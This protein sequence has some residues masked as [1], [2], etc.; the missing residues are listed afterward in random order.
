MNY[1]YLQY[2]MIVLEKMIQVMKYVLNSPKYLVLIYDLGLNSYVVIILSLLS[3][4]LFTY[5]DVY[6]N[7]IKLRVCGK[8]LM[9]NYAEDLVSLM[10]HILYFKLWL[11]VIKSWCC[12]EVCLVVGLK[13]LYN[14]EL[15]CPDY[16]CEELAY[17]INVIRILNDLPKCFIVI[18]RC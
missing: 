14:V 5:D 17:E 4:W 10:I 13:G 8:T 16:D 11:I 12:I 7:W 2:F 15:K 3:C 18:W 6:P 1:G 9:M